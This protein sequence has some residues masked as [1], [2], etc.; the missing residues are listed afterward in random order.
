MDT[1]LGIDWRKAWIERNKKQRKPG[2]SN[3]WDSRAQ[4]FKEHS[5]Q[6]SY[7][8]T[9]LSYLDIEPDLSVLDM[10][11]GS[12]TL[13]IL[14]AQAGHKVIAAD[15]SAGMRQATL[16]RSQ[17]EGL[18]TIT[19]KNLDWNK[20]WK[21][22]GVESK[23]VDVIIASRSTMVDDL[24][25]ALAKLNQ[26]ARKKVAITMTTE[27]GPRGFKPLGGLIDDDNAYVPDYIF[28]VNILF[29]WG[30]YPEL[31][32]ID[33]FQDKGGELEEK[34]V[35]W[36]YISWVPSETPVRSFL[37]EGALPCSSSRQRV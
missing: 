11:A 27:Y 3:Y 7:A 29:Q 19:V 4:D 23:S 25:C 21:E 2:D 28:G 26:T 16:E 8:K 24:A 1:L 18:D 37:E 9:F 5:G 34:L 13:S 6:S 20:D 30:I 10:G 33:T 17:E 36:A 22:S 35:R 15:F 32:Y 12:G 14:L 31:R